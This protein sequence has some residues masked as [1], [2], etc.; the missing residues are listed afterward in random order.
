MSAALRCAIFV[1]ACG[2]AS[3]SVALAGRGARVKI[4]DLEFAPRE[5]VV[6]V[7]DTVAWV[8][9]DIVEHTAT[10]RDGSF[11]VATPIGKPASRRMTAVGVYAY[12]CRLHPN[13]TG[14][15]RVTK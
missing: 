5:I 12:H 10:A 13:M 3:A 4:A 2:L 11:D 7:G 8:N 14:V 9:K 6:H 1:C 15:I